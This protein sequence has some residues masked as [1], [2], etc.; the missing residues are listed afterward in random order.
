[1]F[2][3]DYRPTKRVGIEELDGCI[4]LVCQKLDELDQAGNEK[5][6][7]Y[8]GCLLTLECIRFGNFEYPHEL[9]AVFDNKVQAYTE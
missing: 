8:A 7:F 4:N 5:A 2:V 9:L 6:D 3:G 1:M